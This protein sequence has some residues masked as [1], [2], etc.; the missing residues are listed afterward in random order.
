MEAATKGELAAYD[1]GCGEMM[2]ALRRILDGK[3]S[4]AG[5]ANEPWESLRRR[6]LALVASS[7]AAGGAPQDKI[8]AERYRWLRT[9]AARSDSPPDGV[10]YLHFSARQG[11][12][13]A[14]QDAAVDLDA[15]VDA[16]RDAGQQSEQGGGA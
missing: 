3:D 8:D 16:E 14:D 6:V 7:P 1:Q 13:P 11:D 9:L 5:V 12:W 10:V 15:A 4:G 2:D